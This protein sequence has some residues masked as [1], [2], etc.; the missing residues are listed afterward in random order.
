[1]TSCSS[2]LEPV[3][4]REEPIERRFVRPDRD[5]DHDA[6]TLPAYRAPDTAA[7]SS[8]HWT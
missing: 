5:E 1:M 8:G 4:R 6:N 2:S 3:E 7:T